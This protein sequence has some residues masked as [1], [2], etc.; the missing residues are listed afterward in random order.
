[1]SIYVNISQ[2]TRTLTVADGCQGFS[3][4]RSKASRKRRYKSRTEIC[5][6]RNDS[7]FLESM[8]SFTIQRD[9]L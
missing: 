5:E 7:K 9:D 4:L 1:M 6:A 3:G 8:Q 2:F